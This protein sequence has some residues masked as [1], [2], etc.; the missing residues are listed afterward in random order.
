MNPSTCIC[1]ILPLIIFAQIEW[2]YWLQ[3]IKDNKFIEP[4]EASQ[5]YYKSISPKNT[6]H[7]IL[8][9]DRFKNKK[10]QDILI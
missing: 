9:D 1:Q 2:A 4:W 10:K 5:G 7:K 6:P 8:K 3:T